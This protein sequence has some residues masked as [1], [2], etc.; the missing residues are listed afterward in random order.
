LYRLE[1]RLYPKV[2]EGT[3][4]LVVVRWEIYARLEQLTEPTGK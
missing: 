1:K 4:D 3:E 2:D